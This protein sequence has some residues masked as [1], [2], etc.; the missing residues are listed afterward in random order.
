MLQINY[1]QKNP[2][3]VNI[4]KKYLDNTDAIILEHPYFVNLVKSLDPKIP[5]IYHAHN[6]EFIQKESILN[7]ELLKNVKNGEQTA[8]DLAEQIWVSSESE[9]KQ[10]VKIYGVAEDKIRLLPHGVDISTTPFIE[11]ASHNKIKSKLKEISDKTTF[12]FTGSWHPP[13]LESVEFIISNLSPVNK[14][15]HY[16]IVGSVTDYYVRE[17]PKTKIPENVTMLGLVSDSEKIGIYKL[18][19]YAIN[20]MFSGAGT[21]IKMLEYMAAGLPIISTKFGA[22]GLKFS[23][24]MLVCDKENFRNTIQFAVNSKYEESN[25]ISENFNIIKN[26]Y[27]YDLISRKCNSFLMELFEPKFAH[28]KLFD[29]ILTELNNMQIQSNDELVDSLAKELEVLINFKP[30]S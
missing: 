26:E 5:I 17:H 6:V 14:D 18:S 4:V 28:F 7:P 15:Y 2:E 19:D 1:W 3:Y 25:S 30:S 22:R 21:N 13:N 29:N 8:C 9:K 11:R 23:K 10:F 12:V 16:F 24:N 20:P 27:D